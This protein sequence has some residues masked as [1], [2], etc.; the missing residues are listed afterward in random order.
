M[1]QLSALI[2]KRKIGNCSASF[3]YK[4]WNESPVGSM[5]KIQL[6]D[7]LVPGASG[8]LLNPLWSLLNNPEQC[9][10]NIDSFLYSLDPR[11][12]CKI[13][14][15]NTDLAHPSRTQHINASQLRHITNFITPDAFTCLLLLS[16]VPGYNKMHL[17]IFSHQ[18]FMQLTTFTP[19]SFI[20]S[21]LYDYVYELFFP[22][23]KKQIEEGMYS[24]DIR[25]GIDPSE[26]IQICHYFT[27]VQPGYLK[28]LSEY[29]RDVAQDMV[30]L[31]LI[32]D[33]TFNKMLFINLYSSSDQGW[34]KAGIAG[35]K[36]GHSEDHS[37]GWLPKILRSIKYLQRLQ[38]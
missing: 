12:T 20:Q 31:G 34:V 28:A 23:T 32:H 15:P 27:P 10:K 24:Y 8:C 13:L 4:K 21:K 16:L 35:L 36:H 22:K 25:K 7:N 6:L 18:H 17:E 5:T 37:N 19:F 2:E 29:Y 1:N 30:S 38:S 11:V 9:V 14:E 26:Y 3:L 33:D